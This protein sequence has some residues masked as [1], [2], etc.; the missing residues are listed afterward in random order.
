MLYL[1]LS[2]LLTKRLLC[3]LNDVVCF[4]NGFVCRLTLLGYLFLPESLNLQTF[5]LVYH[6]YV[7][8]REVTASVGY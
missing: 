3:V 1:L 2:F 4:G 5:C 8:S 7:L 6:I